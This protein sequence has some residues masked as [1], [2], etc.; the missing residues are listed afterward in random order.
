MD[1]V[2]CFGTEAKLIDCAYHT[3]TSEDRHSDDI[4]MDCMSTGGTTSNPNGSN[5]ANSS[6][7]TGAETSDHD[8]ELIVALV[9]LVGVILLAIA[10]VSYIIWT[11][12]GLRKKR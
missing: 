5:G 4:W 10:V 8:I 12:H 2:G 7:K 6:D 3:D 11:R 1:N 9:A